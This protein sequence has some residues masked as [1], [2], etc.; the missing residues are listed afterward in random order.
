MKFA[1]NSNGWRGTP[2]DRAIDR[3]AR[4]GYEAIEIA[5]LRGQFG[6]ESW[7]SAE[8]S[9]LKRIVADASMTICNLHAGS[10]GL[11]ADEHALMAIAPA[12][13]AA[14]IDLIQRAIDFAAA[15][16]TDLVCLTSG[17]LPLASSIGDAWSRLVDGLEVCAEYARPRGIRIA[18][19]P[20]PE[21]FIK[22]V[23]EFL[24]LRRRLGDWVEIGL[25]LDI[26][27]S[28]LWIGVS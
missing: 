19:E 20:E 23:F 14:R 16:G 13:R 5:P 18:L 21:L 8:A 24:E 2:I 1:Y 27:H 4:L 28:Q 15:L 3:L 6:P 7:T 9:R 11:I 25:N 22:S 12:S 10:R 26:G 17:P